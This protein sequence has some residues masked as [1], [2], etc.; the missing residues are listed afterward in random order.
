MKKL[1]TVVLLTI[2]MMVQAQEQD[3][4]Q[5]REYKKEHKK[6]MFKKRGAHMTPE[7]RAELQTKRMTLSM[8]LNA[9]Q[10]Q[11]IKAFL[12]TQHQK[13]Q[14]FI[15]KVKAEKSKDSNHENLRFE[16]QKQHLDQKIERKEAFKKILNAEQF[17]TW[18]AQ[19]KTHNKKN[20]KRKSKKRE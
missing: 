20:Y 18:E 16:M 1:M 3:R 10:Q 12:I 2:G 5:K 7:Q 6:E 13:R 19:R 14:A 8:D 4:T 11:E 15:E 9:K 17:A